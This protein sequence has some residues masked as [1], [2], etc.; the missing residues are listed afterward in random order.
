MTERRVFDKETLLDATVNFIPLGMILFFIGLF[1][2]LSPWQPD[3]LTSVVS[4]GLLVTPFVLLALLTYL[5][6]RVI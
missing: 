1:A 5:T 6:M 4:W 2:L 3:M